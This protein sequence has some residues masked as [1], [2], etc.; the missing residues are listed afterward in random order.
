VK[1]PRDIPLVQCKSR[2]GSGE[3]CRNNAIKGRQ[4]CFIGSHNKY[5]ASAGEKFVNFFQNYWL[6][7][8]L[9]VLIAL[10]G[11]S[12]GGVQLVLYY[13]EKNREPLTGQLSGKVIDEEKPVLV[14]FGGNSIVLPVSQLRKGFDVG[15]DISVRNGP[16]ISFPVKLYIEGNRVLFDVAIYDETGTLQ[17]SVVRNEWQ[18]NPNGDYDRNYNLNSF[19]IVD[20]DKIP[21]FQ[22]QLEESNKILIGG[23]II[24]KGQ[25]DIYTPSGIVIGTDKQEAEDKK[26]LIFS[27]P[28]SASLG[29][30]SDTK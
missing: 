8:S 6:G 23:Y 2:T 19:E 24:R 30:P 3:R 9:V 5:R 26:H 18:V 13:R 29:K 21:V 1:K 16:I 4:F 25:Y 14:R 28:S 12:L 11:L 22:I 10:I 17:C 15:R 20:S 27:Y 7:V